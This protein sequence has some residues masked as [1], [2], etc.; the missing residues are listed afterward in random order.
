MIAIRWLAVAI[1]IATL[2]LALWIVIP[3]PT[4]FLLIFGVGG[5]EVSAWLVAA[6]ILATGLVIRDVGHSTLA[7]LVV[8][9]SAVS[10]ALSLS[11]F[12][13]LPSTIRRFDSAMRGVSA[14]PVAPLRVRPIVARDLF[15]GI[16]RVTSRGAWV[17]FENPSGAPL[18]MNIYQ[19]PRQG[20]FPI[21][22]QIYGGAWQRG[23]PSSHANFARWLASSGYV[24]F[25]IDYRHAPRWTWKTLLSDVDSALAWIGAHAA[26]Y[27]GDTSRIVLLGRSAG[28]HL[29]ML[30][31]YRAPPV[32][33]RAVVSYYGPAD[34]VS[35]Y[36]DPPSPDPLR[37]RS[38][39][40][41]F[42]GGTLDQMPE[43]Y[44]AA[45]P[46]SYATRPLPPTLLIYGR[47][48]HTVEAKFG[49]LL[50][51]RL[52]ASG[53]Q[54]AYLEIPWAEHAFDEVFNGPSSQLELYYTERFLAWAVQ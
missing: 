22:V 9:A 6:S 34:L 51:D 52:A 16:P 28:A 8:A 41:A 19:P 10:L 5:P 25:A 12:A 33:V 11:I 38:L 24:V 39:E 30:S 1:G 26:A 27:G 29:A 20:S 43:Q 35:A 13:R 47:R 54:V 44:A 14:E 2:F 42:I 32:R 7:R 3:A 31:A 23:D 18:S 46:I 15:L 17:A 49:A 53:T 45:S 50:R 36:R 21:V 40:E 4:Y 48:D 37:I